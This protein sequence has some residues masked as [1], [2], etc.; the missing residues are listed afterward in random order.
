MVAI[1]RDEI[2]TKVGKHPATNS[3]AC[4][5]QSC[6]FFSELFLRLL[7]DLNESGTLGIKFLNYIG[8][9]LFTKYNRHRDV[10]SNIEHVFFGYDVYEFADRTGIYLVN[11]SI[12]ASLKELRLLRGSPCALYFTMALQKALS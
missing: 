7:K 10:Y 8:L 11:T 9:S 2:T 3:C 5:L 1:L 6:L 4:C 12:V